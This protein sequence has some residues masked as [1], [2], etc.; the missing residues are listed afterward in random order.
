MDTQI[1]VRAPR[2]V[3]RAFDPDVLIDEWTEHMRELVAAGEL[4]E[5]TA[6][7]YRR[8]MGKF[9]AWFASS[10]YKSIGPGAVRSWKAA[11]LGEGRKPSGVNTHL[12]GVRSFF[13]WAVAER[14]LAYNPT[15]D[16]RG[17]KATR[18]KR[19]KRDV[20]TDAEVLRLLAQPDRATVTGKRDAAILHLMAYTGL[21]TVEV[22]RARLG[23]LH[24]N[25]HLILS[26]FGKGHAEADDVVYLVNGDLLEALY[27][28]LAVHP[29]GDDPGA[30]MFCA[31]RRNLGQPLALRTLRAIVKGHYKSAGIRDPRKTTHSLRHTMVTNL[32]RHKVPPTKIMTVTRHKSL[33]TLIAYAHEVERDDDPAEAYVSYTNGK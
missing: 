10:D 4:A 27:D 14:R 25:G 15:L 5:S 19:H 20:L 26:V 24:T 33:D 12:A 16:V 21:R 23:D 18:G 13:R 17:V 32:I 30:P 28:W 9:L 1:A 2:A 6:T 22:Q 29:E 3:S 11:M 7:T 8:G 31:L